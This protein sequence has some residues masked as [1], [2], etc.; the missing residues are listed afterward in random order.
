VGDRDRSKFP[1]GKWKGEDYSD[2]PEKECKFARKRKKASTGCFSPAPGKKKGAM[3]RSV[4]KGGNR[5]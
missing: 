5:L 4:Q 2:A 1:A 3:R